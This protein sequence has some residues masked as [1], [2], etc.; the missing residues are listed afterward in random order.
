MDASHDR[1]ATMNISLPEALRRFVEARA[2]AR[3]SSVSEYI[4]E[5]VREDERRAAAEQTEAALV[6][7]L[8]NESFDRSEV[9]EAIDGIRR[10]RG[11]VASRGASMSRKDIRAAI[12][13]G[14]R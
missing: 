8:E 5:L 9:R 4:R 7:R 6:K 12:K 10:L 14:R 1:M 11:V 3:Y 2:K 13:A